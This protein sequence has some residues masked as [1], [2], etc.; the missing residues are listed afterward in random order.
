MSSS[1]NI[2]L[3]DPD[4][5]SARAPRPAE[6]PARRSTFAGRAGLSSLTRA[7][8]ALVVANLRYW[9]TVTPHVRVQLARWEHAA[10]AIPDP[11]LRGL[12]LG[13]LRDEHF[14]AQVA[15]TLATLAPR[16][17]R[18]SVV[19]AIVAL[20]VMYDYLDVL[21]EQPAAVAPAIEAHHLFAALTDAVTLDAGDGR[22]SD[23]EVPHVYYR[24]RPSSDDGGY[25]HALVETVRST[26]IRLPSAATIAPIAGASAARCAQAQILN[27][28]A[29]RSGTAEARRW[30]TL[31]AAG[32]GLGWQEY[33]AGA[34]ASVLAIGALIAVAAD[35]ATTRAD[36]EDLDALYLSIG[37]LTMLDS[38]V[39]LQEDVA[40]G[41]LGYVQYYDDPELMGTALATVAHDAITRARRAP[42]G[43][44]H[45]MTLAGVVAYYT[46]APTA[47][48][49]FARPLTAPV[50]RALR[51]LITPTIALMRGWR[52]A[53]RVRH[54]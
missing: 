19:E 5:P 53:K 20:Q 7:G 42:N 11:E 6:R 31:Q 48:S 15:A 9:S 4:R 47:S 38:L 24:D 18:A 37:A 22:D 21:S 14:N 26:L 29:S 33:L 39:D 3:V 49:V 50:R 17:Y 52:A 23:V 36:A 45:I 44:H 28:D 34:T 10:R 25:L 1:E 43:P 32:T 8:L 51:P 16:T 2:L 35:P 12:A 27:H 41:Q 13:K 46:S 54:A 40:A 30:A